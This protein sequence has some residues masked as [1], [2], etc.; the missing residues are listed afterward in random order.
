MT[1]LVCR[2]EA[3]DWLVWAG[4]LDEADIDAVDAELDE[5]V[6]DSIQFGE[7]DEFPDIVM[8]DDEWIDANLFGSDTSYEGPELEPL[9]IDFVGACVCWSFSCI[10]NFFDFTD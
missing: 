7:D 8:D 1:Q 9:D 2:D 3:I 5:M 6:L 4:V 10:L